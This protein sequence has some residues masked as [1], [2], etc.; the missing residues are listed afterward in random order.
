MSYRRLKDVPTEE[1]IIGFFVNLFFVIVLKVLVYSSD[2][3]LL[4]LAIFLDGILWASDYCMLLCL[5][6]FVHR[7]YLFLKDRRDFNRCLDEF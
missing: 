1:F 4:N 7:T 5:F 2:P 3:L 6:V